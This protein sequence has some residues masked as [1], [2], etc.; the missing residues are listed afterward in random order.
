MARKLLSTFPGL[1][2]SGHRV[3]SPATPGYNCIAWAA[4]DTTRWW[5]PDAFQIAYWPA[6]VPREE[7]VETFVQAYRTL[8]FEECESRALE[9]GY[10]KVALFAVGDR[11]KH[12]AR[13]LP[14]GAWSS[15]LGCE[16]DIEHT[17]ESLEGRLYGKVVKV[18]RRRVE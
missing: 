10:E 6:G 5:W 3:T 17:L 11:P 9:S 15:K 7:T 2:G 8:S 13:Q 14:D 1:A 18:L 12:V 4:G 16:V